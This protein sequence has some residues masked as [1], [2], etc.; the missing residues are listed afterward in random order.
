MT[1]NALVEIEVLTGSGCGHCQS[2]L[3]LVREVIE[4]LGD[5]RVHYREVNVVAEIDYAV[6]LGLL[7][8]PALALNGELVFPVP[9]NKAELRQTLTEMLGIH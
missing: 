4:E 6:S 3:G 9:P 8:T 2:A 5:D 1:S 7:R